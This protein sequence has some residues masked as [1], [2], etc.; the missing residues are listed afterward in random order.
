MRNLDEKIEKKED[1]I[2]ITIYANGEKKEIYREPSTYELNNHVSIV[3][4]A[5][6][7]VRDHIIGINTH[8]LLDYPQEICVEIEYKNRKAK[9]E[10]KI[11]PIKK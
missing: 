5:Y 10:I 3:E 8:E 6:G 11:K 1:K 9:C 2:K 4:S 7:M